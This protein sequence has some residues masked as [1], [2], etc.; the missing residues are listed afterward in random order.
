[1]TFYVSWFCP[2]HGW[3]TNSPWRFCHGLIECIIPLPPEFSILNVSINSLL[4]SFRFLLDSNHGLFATIQFINCRFWGMAWQIRLSPLRMSHIRFWILWNC[5][6][7][8]TYA[9]MWWV[10]W[11]Q[12]K[13]SK[14]FFL[15][16]WILSC[17]SE[18][19]VRQFDTCLLFI[20]NWLHC[21]HAGAVKCWPRAMLLRTNLKEILL[22][23]SVKS[24]HVHTHRTWAF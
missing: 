21:W 16:V 4:F 23:M 1:M 13:S 22:C 11:C 12:V 7:M 3:F 2:N 6:Q 9:W 10:C 19:C 20:G 5:A 24:N 8:E 14:S 15:P 17:S 18:T